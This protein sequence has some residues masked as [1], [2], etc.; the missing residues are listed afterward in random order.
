MSLSVNAETGDSLNLR[1]ALIA[2]PHVGFAVERA[3]HAVQFARYIK[4]INEAEVDVVLVAGDLVD[5]GRAEEFTAY[6]QLA[7]HFDAQA[8]AVAGNHDVGA[9]AVGERERSVTAARLKRYRD[10]QGP[11]YYTAQLSPHIRLLA[12][13]TSLINSGL[14]EETEQ[15]SWIEGIAVEDYNGQTIVLMHYPLFVDNVDEP[16]SYFNLPPIDRH[17]LLDLLQQIGDVTILTGHLHRSIQHEHQGISIFTTAPVS[18]GL[19]RGV[20][21]IGWSLLTLTPDGKLTVHPQLERDVV[22][23]KVVGEE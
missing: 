10:S 5:Q 6:E 4:Q 22:A 13:N 19:P 16:N 2:D 18:F 17:R 11:D 9:R 3:H 14:P 23:I 12:I 21:Q 20:Q 15:W 1:I 8:Y 7:E